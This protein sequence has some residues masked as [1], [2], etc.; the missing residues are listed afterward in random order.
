MLDEFK[1]CGRVA[2]TAKTTSYH[3]LILA[4]AV[5]F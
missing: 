3:L 4:E 5:S 2:Q 1:R